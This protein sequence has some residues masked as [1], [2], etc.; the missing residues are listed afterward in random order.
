MMGDDR[1]DR[2]R[3]ARVVSGQSKGDERDK[4][5]LFYLPAPPAHL[6]VRAGRV[7]IPRARPRW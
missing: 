6:A 7:Q 2:Q 5:L 1:A 4:K 3:G